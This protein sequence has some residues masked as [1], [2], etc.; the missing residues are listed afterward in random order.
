MVVGKAEKGSVKFLTLKRKGSMNVDLGVS[1]MYLSVT[2]K[3]LFDKICDYYG[4]SASAVMR[5]FMSTYCKTHYI[6]LMDDPFF[7]EVGRL[8]PPERDFDE[9][10]KQLYRLEVIR[11]KNIPADLQTKKD[12]IIKVYEQANKNRKVET[13]LG[14]YCDND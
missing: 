1:S 11:L 9:F 10:A 2:Y 14:D 4:V 5:D 7:S 12:D 6:E 8:A 13:I 3:H